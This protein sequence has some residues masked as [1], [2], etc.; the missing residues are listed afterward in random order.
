MKK[1]KVFDDR[2]GFI[3]VTD[4]SH[5]ITTPDVEMHEC[6]TYISDSFFLHG[7]VTYIKQS[8]QAPTQIVSW[9]HTPWG[10][11]LVL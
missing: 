9:S 3:W 11:T 4:Q 8:A 10:S 7:T 1:V 5:G 6:V 2:L